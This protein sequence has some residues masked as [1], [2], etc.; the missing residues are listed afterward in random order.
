M[1]QTR[2]VDRYAIEQLGIPGVVLM[3]NAGRNAADLIERW[4]VARVR[5]ATR[6]ARVAIV[7]GRGNNGGDGFVVARH[8]AHRTIAGRGLKPADR[9]EVLYE[10]ITSRLPDAGEAKV[11]LKMLEDL[12][13]IYRDKTELA[14]NLCEGVQLQ[15]GASAPELA[16]WTMLVSTIYNLDITKTRD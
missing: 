11:F 2:A 14:K 9:L 16:A 13:S 7:C 5:P 4:A 3:E 1:A 10:T 15:E 8:L 6:P 12:E